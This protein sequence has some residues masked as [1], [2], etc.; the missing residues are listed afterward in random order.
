[1]DNS[2]SL[3]IT[4]ELHQ[5]KQTINTLMRKLEDIERRYAIKVSMLSSELEEQK[6]LVANLTKK[7]DENEST[8]TTAKP[9]EFSPYSQPKSIWGV[10]D[11]G[12]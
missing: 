1:M 9:R 12:K 8:K 5:Q 10:I 4:I 3:S 6:R 11:G 7:L 2:A